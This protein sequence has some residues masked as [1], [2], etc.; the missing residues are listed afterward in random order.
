MLLRP[1]F[2]NSKEVSACVAVFVEE[3][4]C[5]DKRMKE[6]VKYVQMERI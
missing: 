4:V 2:L 6:F 1:Y 5:L 3:S